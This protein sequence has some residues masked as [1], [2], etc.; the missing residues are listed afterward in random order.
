MIF[1]VCTVFGVQFS[2]FLRLPLT[3]NPQIDW[4]TLKNFDY[5][6]RETAYTNLKPFA[7]I[8]T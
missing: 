6:E 7:A 8:G 2:Y 3:T 1:R 5:P 4:E